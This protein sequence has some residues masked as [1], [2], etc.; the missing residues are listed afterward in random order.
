[1][2]T[3]VMSWFMS[4]DMDPVTRIQILDEADCISKSTNTRGKSMTPTI[5]PADRILYDYW[6][7]RS[8]TLNLD[9]LYFAKKLT[10]CRTLPFVEGLN[11]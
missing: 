7:K 11:W 8:K 9:H 2:E 6:L 4:K 1:M 10:L 3:L 5:R